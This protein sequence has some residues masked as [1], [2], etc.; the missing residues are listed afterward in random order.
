MTGLTQTEQ[1]HADKMHARYG[2][3]LDAVNRVRCPKCGAAPF[4]DCRTSGG[5]PM[6]MKYHAKRWEAAPTPSTGYKLGGSATTP[7][8]KLSKS[9]GKVSFPKSMRDNLTQKVCRHCGGI[10]HMY[11]KGTRIPHD[12]WGAYG[13][14]KD[15]GCVC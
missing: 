7:K 11:R 2:G 13:V 12:L 3:N 10:K 4:Q 8:V 6:D 9:A 15:A 5:M 14:A 1:T